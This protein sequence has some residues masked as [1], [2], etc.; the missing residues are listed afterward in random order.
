MSGNGSKYFNLRHAFW[1]KMDFHQR[2][3]QSNYLISSLFSVR[4][5]FDI[6]RDFTCNSAVS[7]LSSLIFCIQLN[8]TF[9]MINTK[10]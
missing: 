1:N 2:L 3:G 10:F 6:K 5:V 4:S 9:L 8:I 7:Q